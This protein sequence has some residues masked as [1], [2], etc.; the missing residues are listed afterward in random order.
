MLGTAL[1]ALVLIGS[2]YADAIFTP[3]DHPQNN[4]EN[5]LLK[6]PNGHEVSGNPLDGHTNHTNT[7]V[8]FS[9]TT[10]LP[11]QTCLSGKGG[12]SD[13]DA[14]PGFGTFIHNITITI[15]ANSSG[16]ASALGC[17]FQDLIVNPFKE[18]VA[19]DVDVTV[20]TNQGTFTDTAF[21]NMNG[22]NFLTI[23]VTPGDA[24]HSVTLDSGPG[25]QDLKQTRISGPFAVIPEPASLLLLGSGV[26]LLLHGF[27]R[28][29]M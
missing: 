15:P 10:C 2:A 26:L 11:G 23:T 19:H 8:Q 29:L 7:D 1:A 14:G 9:S 28:K 25:F 4:E 21:G 6:G 13:V 24:I 17:T 18:A 5:V 12:Q 27:R 22:N 3:G 20:V 16:C